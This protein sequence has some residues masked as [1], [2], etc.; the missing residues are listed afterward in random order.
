MNI[1]DRI[2]AGRQA[3]KWSQADLAD[4]S[5]VKQQMI[6]KLE[7]GKSETT[8]DLVSL[9]QALDTT[10][11]YLQ[12]G[13][14]TS[15]EKKEISP[16][17]SPEVQA[18]VELYLHAPEAGQKAAQSILATFAKA[19]KSGPQHPPSAVAHTAAERRLLKVFRS[20]D[21]GARAHWLDL[22]E[23]YQFSAPDELP[24]G[25]A[26][27]ADQKS[28]HRQPPIKKL[29]KREDKDDQSESGGSTPSS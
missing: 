28:A 14:E 24:E 25:V 26:S 9:A 6:S 10:A 8:A 21:K 7:T 20:K 2:K 27:L 17:L 23:H 16:E 13:K 18:V 29:R 22:M 11:E 5:G 4:A 12:T 15:D 19:A 3:K 1:G